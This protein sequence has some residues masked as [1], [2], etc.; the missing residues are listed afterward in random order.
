[1]ADSSSTLTL[2]MTARMGIVEV[3]S[4]PPDAE[5]WVDG[6]QQGVTPNELTLSALSHQIEIRLSGFAE[7]AREV[8][9]RPGLLT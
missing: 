6:E 8:T 2:S 1:M 4:D 3:R 5:I 7:Q 9:P